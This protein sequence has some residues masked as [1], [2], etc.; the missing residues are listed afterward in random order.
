MI[1]ITCAFC[2][3]STTGPAFTWETLNGWLDTHQAAK[4]SDVA[5]IKDDPEA[6]E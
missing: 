1:T 3:W 5:D 4:H 6:D 2:D